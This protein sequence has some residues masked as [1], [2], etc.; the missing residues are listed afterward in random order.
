LSPPLLVPPN[1][2]TPEELQQSI[3]ALFE[4]KSVPVAEIPKLCK[5][6]RHLGVDEEKLQQLIDDGRVSLLDGT[7]KQGAPI[8]AIRVGLVRKEAKEIKPKK[9]KG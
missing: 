4:A 7:I 1:T 3:Y 5:I 6:E 8:W 9:K 2:I